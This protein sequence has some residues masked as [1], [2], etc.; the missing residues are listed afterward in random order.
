MSKNSIE[1]INDVIIKEIL[2]NLSLACIEEIKELV[3]EILIDTDHQ[4]D[5]ETEHAQGMRATAIQVEWI[6]KD[7][8][9]KIKQVKVK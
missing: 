2:K 3:N 1:I 8:K 5:R 6:L 4:D 7:Y 9:K